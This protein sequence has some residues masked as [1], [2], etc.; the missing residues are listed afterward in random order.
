M[1]SGIDASEMKTPANFLG[2]KSFGESG[3]KCGVIL[4]RSK[5]NHKI[6]GF[7]KLKSQDL[8]F[9]FVKSGSR[10]AQSLLFTEFA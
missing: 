6:F 9:D 10:K 7:R 4:R 3:S 2:A 5:F 1:S 8:V